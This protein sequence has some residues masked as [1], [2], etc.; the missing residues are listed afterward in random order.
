VR[1]ELRDMLRGLGVTS[2]KWKCKSRVAR[3]NVGDPVWAL[4]VWSTNNMGE[5]GEPSRDYFPGIAVREM[6]TKMLIYI[7]PNSPGREDP[8]L[9]FDGKGFCKI[10]LSRIERREGEPVKVCR[11]C[12]QPEFVGHALGFSC[13]PDN[14][15]MAA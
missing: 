4:T 1:D 8:E 11:H 15:W 3:I 9:A 14:S 13:N 12:Q 10:P 5:S 7:A 2:I 6:G